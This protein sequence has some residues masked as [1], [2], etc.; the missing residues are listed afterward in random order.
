VLTQALLIYETLRISAPTVVESI[1]GHVE[2][3]TVDRRLRSWGESCVRHA[4][5]DLQIL[6]RERVDWSHAYVMMSNHQS[7]FDIPA[8]SM[9]TSGKVRFIAKKEL[10]RVPIWGPAMRAAGIISIDRQNRERAIAS[11]RVAAETLRRGSNIW[12][13]PEGTRSVDGK[14]GPLKKGGFVLALETGAPILP[15]AVV[16][17]RDAWTPRTLD[18]RRGVKAQVIFGDP[19]PTS[20]RTRPELMAEV[21]TFL[22]AHLG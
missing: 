21:E 15:V 9:A 22:R 20:G 14:L 6:G 13:A 10:F 19:I 3:D 18:I 2:S 12:I 5:M 11:L 1:V 8:L 4:A 17:T 16:G 7:Y